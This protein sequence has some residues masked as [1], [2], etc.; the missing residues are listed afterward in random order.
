MFLLHIFDVIFLNEKGQLTEGA[1]SNIF[2]NQSGRWLTPSGNC[3]LLP[4]I[5]RKLWLSEDTNAME[6]ILH[7]EDLLNCEEIV[8]TNSLRGRTKVSKVYFNKNEFREF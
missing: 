3:G 6:D 8:L 7:L 4:G 5:E 1:I 2:I